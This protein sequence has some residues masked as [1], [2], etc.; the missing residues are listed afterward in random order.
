[1]H[2]HSG[3]I[4]CQ[5]CQCTLTSLHTKWHARKSLESVWEQIG[6]AWEV[7]TWSVLV[8]QCCGVLGGLP[9]E[10]YSAVVLEAG[11]GEGPREEVGPGQRAS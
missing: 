3:V 1:M 8:S 2:K 7:A 6:A 5:G 10:L 9:A 4:V 11:G